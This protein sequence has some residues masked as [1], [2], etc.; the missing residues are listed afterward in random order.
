MKITIPTKLESL[1]MSIFSKNNLTVD[2]KNILIQIDKD[3]E[4]ILIKED[5]NYE[6]SVHKDKI[7]Y[8]YSDKDRVYCYANGEYF[9]SKIKLYEF[10]KLRSNGF[11]RVNKQEVVNFNFVKQF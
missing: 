10:E 2:E 1:V 5:I 11:V 4:I 8:V 9:R 3:E 7:T 6:I